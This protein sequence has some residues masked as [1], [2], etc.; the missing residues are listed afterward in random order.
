MRRAPLHT[1]HSPS[2]LSLLKLIPN[3]QKFHHPTFN[4]KIPIHT[5]DLIYFNFVPG[6]YQS[7][8][9]SSKILLDINNFHCG[10]LASRL[11]NRPREGLWVYWATG[12]LDMKPVVRH[13][14]QKR[15][16]T[17][18]IEELQKRGFD[19]DGK[20]AVN[21]KASGAG[22][23]GLYGTLS[24]GAH[25]AL[26]LAKGGELRRQMGLMVQRLEDMC[27]NQRIK[28]VNDEER[29]KA[30]GPRRGNYKRGTK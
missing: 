10:P 6:Y 20:C 18:L 22:K 23:N 28:R 21:G 17:A 12:T 11:L 7:S 26:P 24:I 3:L 30:V 27:E 29:E 19:K 25:R 14:C 2:Q 16:K 13:R 5:V 1:L 8:H 4:K 9:H 15:M